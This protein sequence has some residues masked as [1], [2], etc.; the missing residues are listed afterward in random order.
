MLRHRE[1]EGLIMGKT[2]TYSNAQLMLP[3]FVF[4]TRFSF[5]DLLMYLFE[6]QNAR[7]ERHQMT[8][9]TKSINISFPES[10]RVSRVSE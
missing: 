3:S 5:E 7:E 2:C 4:L 1:L 9:T 10:H 6:R 8:A